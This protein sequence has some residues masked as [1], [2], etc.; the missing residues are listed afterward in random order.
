MSTSSAV[1]ICSNALQRLGG[2]PIS[3]F[4]DGT[5]HAGL[6]ANLWPGVRDALLR[7][8]P[9]NC[10][11]KRVILAP[12]AE[13]PAFDYSHKFL[14]PGDWLKTLQV[15]KRGMVPSFQVEGRCILSSTTQ[16]PL[17][18]IFRNENTATWDDSLVNAAT[19]AMA[20]AMAYPVTASASMRD[21]MLQEAQF[22]LKRAKADDGQDNPPEEFEA[23]DLIHARF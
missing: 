20:A 1:S 5:V 17:V 6:A 14:L 7:S 15:G 12:A 21:S 9:W 22:E 11:T 2:K 3:S 23:S 18:Y 16:L 8:H 13:S 10:A 19:L 4:E